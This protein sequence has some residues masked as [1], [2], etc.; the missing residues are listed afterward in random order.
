MSAVAAVCS[1]S[2]HIQARMNVSLVISEVQEQPNVATPSFRC[3]AGAAV[4]ALW[5]LCC[6]PAGPAVALA[7]CKGGTPFSPPAT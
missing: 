5:R 1:V 2:P 4:R 6:L 3:Q 7:C